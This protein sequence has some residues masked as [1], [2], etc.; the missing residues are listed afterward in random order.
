M[1]CRR[2]WREIRGAGSSKFRFRLRKVNFEP[3]DP[4][5]Y[6]TVRSAPEAARVNVPVTH[7]LANEGSTE[8]TIVEFELK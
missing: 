3:R 4:V 5:H 8:G 1:W 6:T 7:S 2:S